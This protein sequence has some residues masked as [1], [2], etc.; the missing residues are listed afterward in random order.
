MHSQLRHYM[1]L[2]SQLHTDLSLENKP[3]MCASNGRLHGLQN[4]EVS[5]RQNL[6]PVGNVCTVPMLPTP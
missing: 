6:F 5:K 4:L 2:L 1:E 3:A